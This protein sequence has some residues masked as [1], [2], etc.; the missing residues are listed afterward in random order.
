MNIAVNKKARHDYE[1]LEKL[2]AGIVLTGAEA[3]SAKSG[4]LN[5]RGAHLIIRGGEAYLIGAQIMPYKCGHQGE[6]YDA[7]A[8]RKLLLKRKE[9]SRLIGK[10]EEERLTIIPISAYINKSGR[11]KITLAVARG[12]REYEK[13][14]TIKKRE[15]EKEARG[16]MK[17]GMKR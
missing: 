8:T 12:K 17:S 10:K 14:A 5:L 9:I 3:K 11:V 6:G 16:A 4:G 2:D 1:F 15:T 7:A 13:R